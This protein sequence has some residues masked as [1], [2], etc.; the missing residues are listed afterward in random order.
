MAFEASVRG[1]GGNVGCLGRRLI[2]SHTHHRHKM[3]TPVLVPPILSVFPAGSTAVV[4][5]ESGSGTRSGFL[6]QGMQPQAH[7]VFGFQSVF[8]SLEQGGTRMRY[9]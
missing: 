9:G 5:Q 8:G 4:M 1:S 7:A 3:F 2:G 6:T